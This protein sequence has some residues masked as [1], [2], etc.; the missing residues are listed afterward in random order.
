MNRVKKITYHDGSY[1]DY[2]YDVVGRV[3]RIDDTISG[4][5]D[6]TYND[7]GCTTCTGRGMDRISK[8]VT[9]LGTVDYTYDKVGR[10]LTMTVAGQPVVNYVYDAAGRMTSMNRKI[11]SK[12]RTYTLTYDN[13]SRRTTQKIP[14]SLNNKF[15]TTTYGYDI[16][17]RLL[18]MLQQGPSAQ[19]ENLLYEYDPNG[20]RTKFTRNTA[21]PSRDA[22]TSATYD[23]ANEILTFQPLPGSAKNMTY[24]NNGNLSTVTNN[25]GTTTYTW[26]VRNRLVAINGYK[27]DCSA[28]TASFQYDAIGRRT[29]KTI[30]GTTTQ[31][32]YDGLDI[33]Q[34]KQAG[35]VTANYIRTLN[36]AEPLT[37]IRGSTN[38]H[39]VLDALG[40]VIALTDDSG[41][42]KTT[43]T[44]DPFGNVTVSGES[45]DNPFQYTGRENDGTGLYYYRA[46]YYSPE[47]QRFISEDLIWFNGGSINLYEY[48][49]NNS[50]NSTDPSGLFAYKPGVP[51]ATGGLLTLLNCIEKCYGS[52][53]SIMGRFYFLLTIT[54]LRGLHFFADSFY[55]GRMITNRFSLGRVY[56]KTIANEYPGA[57]YHVVK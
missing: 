12:T 3:D 32:V 41:V 21:Q 29:A 17:N 49:G 46:R 25:C 22:V 4:Y 14:L 33:I 13:A 42:V 44:Y 53:K 24:D 54:Y 28:L 51:P 30:N 47:L 20:N 8:E 26:D 38:R 16:A 10:R 43:Y 27:P 37:R 7:F 35:S 40:S 1:T 23:D 19:I 18:S 2:T 45:S 50:I 34:E 55:Y 11:G 48:V 5:I 9:S 36:I 39:Y 15:V 57:F 6:Y 31:Y 56:G 52:F